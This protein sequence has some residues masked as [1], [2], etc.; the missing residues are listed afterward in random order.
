MV[1]ISLH[2]CG[3]C[4]HFRLFPADKMCCERRYL[5]EWMQWA[6]HHNRNYKRDAEI[7]STG[8]WSIFRSEQI[9]SNAEWPFVSATLFVRLFLLTEGIH[10]FRLVRSFRAIHVHIHRKWSHAANMYSSNTDIQLAD[11]DMTFAA[12]YNLPN[13]TINWRPPIVLLRLENGAKFGA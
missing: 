6:P 7:S 11:Y 5:G 10:P 3:L 2:G 1:C 4:W 9:N 12:G 13:I 8:Y